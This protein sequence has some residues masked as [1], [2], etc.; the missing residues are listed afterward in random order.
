MCLNVYDNGVFG[1][2]VFVVDEKVYWLFL[3]KELLGDE[4]LLEFE[5]IF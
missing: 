2:M 4:E 5:F 3:M 1:F